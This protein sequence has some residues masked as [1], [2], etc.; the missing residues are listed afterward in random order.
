MATPAKQLPGNAPAERPAGLPTRLDVDLVTPRGVVAHEATDGLTAPGEEGEFEL[1]PG[2]VPLLVAL[3]PGVLIIGERVRTRYAVSSG[4]LR[5][6][7]TGRVEVLVEQAVL[8]ADVDVE[9]AKSDLRTAET[10]LLKWG[11][12]A[13]DGDYKNLRHRADWA[14]ARI[15][16][17]S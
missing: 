15:A 6:D 7:P 11:D 5:V 8:G 14:Q 12:K 2:H 3:K 16:A 13:M 17:A 4:Y 9:S 1:L 10:E